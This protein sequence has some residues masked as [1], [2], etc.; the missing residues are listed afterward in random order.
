MRRIEVSEN[1]SFRLAGG[2][3]GTNAIEPLGNA[4][5]VLLRLRDA[6]KSRDDAATRKEIP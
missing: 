4:E 5:P 6:S 3:P 2:M 1:G